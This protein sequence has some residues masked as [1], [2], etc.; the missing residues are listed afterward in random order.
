M[1]ITRHSKRTIEESFKKQQQVASVLEQF[2]MIMSA[3]PS[4]KADVSRQ[5]STSNKDDVDDKDDDD[6]PTKLKLNQKVEVDVRGNKRQWYEGIVIG[7][8]EDG[9]FDVRMMGAHAHMGLLTSLTRAEVEPFGTH[10]KSRKGEGI[11]HWDGMTDSEDEDW[12]D[13]SDDDERT[14]DD[15]KEVK[16]ALEFRHRDRIN[17]LVAKANGNADHC[18]ALLI[19]LADQADFKPFSSFDLL[20]DA[21]VPDSSY[22]AEP[23]QEQLQP[24]E[25]M[26][27]LNML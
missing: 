4:K 15:K 11:W 3:K 24:D 18:C 23:S 1:R 8:N 27:L 21:L 7:V 9:T 2:K 20:L 12:R 26:V 19:H 22:A 17:E 13:D 10:A 16:A 25:P 5:A 6:D 14:T